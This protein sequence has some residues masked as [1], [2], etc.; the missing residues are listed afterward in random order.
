MISRT[1]FT[2]LHHSA[3]LLIAT[4]LGLLLVYVAPPVLL[5][6]APVRAASLGAATWLLMAVAY[7]PALRFYKQSP[8]WAPLLPL[9]AAFYLGATLHSALSYW[10][11]TG[12]MWKGRT[13]DSRRVLIARQ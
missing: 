10:R 4:V 7:F 11:G 2:Q 8:F 12:G 9:V 5:F 3:L 13:Q 1:A 6:A